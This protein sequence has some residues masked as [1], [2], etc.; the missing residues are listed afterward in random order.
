[1]NVET[2]MT[3]LALPPEARVDQRIPK[4]LLLEHGAPTAADKRRIKEGIDELTWLATLKPTTI[5]VP[6][7]RDEAREYL[8]TAVLSLKLATGAKAARLTELVHRAIPYPIL[9]ILNNPE[10]ISLSLAHLRWSQGQSGKT[11]LD[12]PP[13]CHSA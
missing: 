11:V 9:L 13:I 6:A 7:Y 5:G 10:C 4:K 12:A 1:M 3:A 2:I 8:E